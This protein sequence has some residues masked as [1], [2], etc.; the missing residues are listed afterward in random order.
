M[1]I[2]DR[3]KGLSEGRN[4]AVTFGTFHA[5]FFTI[6]KAASVTHPITR[7]SSALVSIPLLAL[8]VYCLLY[9]STA[10]VCPSRT[11]TLIH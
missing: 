5:V 11:G 4:S 7:T 9:T 3:F 6:L 1:C 10:A 2:R 8:F